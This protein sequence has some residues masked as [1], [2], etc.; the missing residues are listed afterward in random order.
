MEFLFFDLDGTLTEPYEGISKSILYALSRFGLP[1]PGEEALRACIGPPLYDS[2]EHR[3]GLGKE[4]SL[5]A[6]RLFRE[7]YHDVGWQENALLPG[8]AEALRTLSAAG[9]KLAVATGKPTLFAERI[10]RKFGVFGCFSAVV[11]SNLDGTMTEKKEE[12][13]EAMRRLC[14]PREQ[15]AMIGDRKYDV[16]GAHALG[17][18]AAGVTFGY[19]E[20]GELEAAGAD[21]VFASFPALTAYFL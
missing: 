21:A 6:V 16:E 4:G 19:A 18:F 3:F 20:E 12:L 11:G 13:G 5:E 2:F 9:K 1:D 15:S 14:A 7:R 17:V 8:A 10:L